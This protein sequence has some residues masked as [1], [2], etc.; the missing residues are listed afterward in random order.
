MGCSSSK[1]SGGKVS[2]TH[3]SDPKIK[4]HVTFNADFLKT[5]KFN[6]KQAQI[7]TSKSGFHSQNSLGSGSYSTV[8]RNT[9][10][11]LE[12]FQ[13][14]VKSMPKMISKAYQSSKKSK[15]K[16]GE[17]DIVEMDMKG[18]IYHELDLLEKIDHPGISKY[19]TCYEDS[20]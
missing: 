18:S 12:I 14:A 10:G 20:K 15:R 8:S 11:P 2:L 19:F 1:A 17:K 3:P 13:V 4:D 6:P 7:S 16:K 5:T 9:R